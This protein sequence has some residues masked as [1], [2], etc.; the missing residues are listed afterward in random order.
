MQVE[1][2]CVND[3]ALAALWK[4]HAWEARQDLVVV[5]AFHSRNDVTLQLND[6]LTIKTWLPSALTND[7]GHHISVFLMNKRSNIR[8]FVL[9]LCYE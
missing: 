6:R 4:L 9:G 3:L 7:V 5:V 2:V 8:L 1:L